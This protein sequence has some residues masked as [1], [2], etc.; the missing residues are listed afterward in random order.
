MLIQ[1]WIYLGFV[2]YGFLSF[3]FTLFWLS[4]WISEKRL[5]RASRKLDFEARLKN[6][7]ILHKG[8]IF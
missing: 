4:L 3:V 1:E 5:Q 2:I 6:G 7:E 8:N